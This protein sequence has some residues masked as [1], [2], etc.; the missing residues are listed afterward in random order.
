MASFSYTAGAGLTTELLSGSGLSFFGSDGYGASIAVGAYQGRTFITGSNGSP[1]IAESNQVAYQNSGS[2]IIGQTGSGIGCNYVP[3]VNSTLRINFTHS[4]NINVVNTKLYGYDRV[5]YLNGPSGVVLKAF[6]A[7]HPNSSSS[8]AGSG[9]T[10][11]TTLDGSGSYLTLANSPGQSGFWA[12]NGSDSTRVD[13]THHWFVNLSCSP[14]TV[15]SKTF[16]LWV[17]NEYY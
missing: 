6:E 8:V 16:G 11:W 13:Q 17:Q 7:I 2:G 3:N 4:S 14:S 5:S 12:G 9:D 1:N 10:T 15:G